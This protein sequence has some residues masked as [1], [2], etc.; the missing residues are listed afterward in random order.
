M[1]NNKVMDNDEHQAILLSSQFQRLLRIRTR[2]RYFLTS[3]VLLLHAFFVG[4]IAFYRQ[5]FSQPIAEGSSIPVGIVVTV[6]VI[7]LMISLE[8]IYIWISDKTFEPLQQR[9]LAEVHHHG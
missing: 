1:Q 3:M 7:V 5:W 9:V 6:I 8:V 2:L 4:G